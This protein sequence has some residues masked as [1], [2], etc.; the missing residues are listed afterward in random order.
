MPPQIMVATATRSLSIPVGEFQVI[1]HAI[2][3]VSVDVID[4]WAFNDCIY[5]LDVEMHKGVIR[6]ERN[7]F[8]RYRLLRGI[9]LPGV[10]SIGVLAFADCDRLEDVEFGD[11]L[12]VIGNMAFQDCRSLRSITIPSSVR[13]IGNSA[14]YGCSENL[15]HVELPEGLDKIGLYTFTECKSLRRIEM[16]L[17]GDM[18]AN[19]AFSFC[20]KLT[21]V[22]LIGTTHKTISL[23]HLECWRIEIYDEISRICQLLPPTSPGQETE[24]IREWIRSIIRLIEHYK[25]EHYKLLKEATIILEIAI[26]KAKFDESEGKLFEAGAKKAKVDTDC[27][28]EEARVI[29]GSDVIIKNVLPFLLLN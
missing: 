9:K 16:P 5:L 7:A 15:T 28:R 24:V 14:F 20:D 13:S 23:F 11:K 3:D 2:I 18:I 25:T 6:I 21:R 10:E 27:A 29:C 17:N 22:D 19:N 8:N 26:W 1:T 4:E 12:E